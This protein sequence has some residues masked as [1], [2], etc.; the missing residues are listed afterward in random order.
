MIAILDFGSQYSE[1]IAR[2]IRETQVYSEVLPYNTSAEKLLQS[3]IK[4]IILSGGPSSVYDEGAPQC[5][6]KIFDLGIPVLGVCYGMQLMAKQLGGNVERAD[7][8]EYGKAELQ[9]DD[10]IDLL[11]NVDTGIT[12]WMSHG[13]SVVDLP[14]GF[15]VIAHTA[16]TP[17]AAIADHVKK[18]YGVQ[19][20]PEV[21]HSAGGM[22][23]ICNFVYHICK[24]EPNWTTD[25]FIE[26]AIREIRE[27]VG[28]KRV[29]LALSGGVDSSTLA[30]LL[31]KAIGDQLTCMFIDQGF[32]RK[33]EPER[34][35][36]LFEEQFHIHVEYVNARERFLAK[37]KGVT[38]P[39][40]KRKIIGGEFINVFEEESSR[41]GPFDFLAQG[42]LYPDVIESADT[43]VDPATGKRVA[44]KIKSH[45]NVGGLPENLRFTL[46]EPLR[47]L[48][49]D[50]VRKVGTALGL[51]EEIVKR[52]PFPGP[53]LAIRII[54]EITSE[55]LNTLR[56]ADLIVRQ[57]INRAGQYNNLWQAF[58]VLLPTVRSVGVM[59]DKRT[60]SNPV[61]L[62]LVSSEDG[63]TADWARV[64]YE[65]L[66]T[67]SNRIVNEVEGV[68]RVVLDITSKPPGT[69]EWE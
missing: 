18:L 10:P 43:N 54:G 47:K 32:M 24:C 64:P 13:D 46:V 52:Q 22:A 51:P 65:L 62:R 59:G 45:H 38:D 6:P 3:N 69:I 34:L 33:L 9:I 1:L 58:A 29:L 55:R 35:V 63:M 42:T 7:R 41:L 19:F 36:K 56:D 39:E 14:N 68:N 25:A 16:N 49:K 48:F 37:V 40:Q 61:V 66:E 67:I 53:G 27:Q 11:F 44:V 50:E 2:R 23:M 8:G 31:H 17:C 26:N 12:M 20:H 5:D 4:G 60:Y 21:V 57:E 30:F 15:E 28:T